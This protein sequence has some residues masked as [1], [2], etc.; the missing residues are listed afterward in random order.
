MSLFP[1][2]NFN[3]CINNNSFLKYKIEQKYKSKQKPKVVKD[4]FIPEAS[5]NLSPSEPDYFCLSDPA[6]STKCNLEVFTFKTPSLSNVLH[7]KLK[8]NTECERLESQFIRVIPICRLLEPFSRIL[9]AYSEEIILSY[10]KFS[11]QTPLKLSSL[12]CKL[13]FSSLESKSKIYSLYISKKLQD[14]VYSF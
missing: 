7:Q 14:I 5:F 6:K 4:L 10:T 8:Q 3:Q 11:T 13:L 2:R 1:I 12:S 9:S